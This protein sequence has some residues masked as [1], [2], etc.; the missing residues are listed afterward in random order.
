[1]PLT[2]GSRIVVRYATDQALWHERIALKQLQGSR[3]LLLTPDRDI[4][5]EDISIPGRGAVAAVRF[6]RDD[7]SFLGHGGLDCYRF[8]DST[9]GELPEE[10]LAEWIQECDALG[11]ETLPVQDNL[12]ATAIGGT[13]IGPAPR[14][15]NAGNLISDALAQSAPTPPA[16]KWLVLDGAKDCLAGSTVKDDWEIVRLGTKGV[17]RLGSGEV[18]FIHLVS[19]PSADAQSSGDVVID[20]K[21][22]ALERDRVDPR[23]LP[24]KHDPLGKR[25]IDFKDACDNSAPAK[26]ADFPIQGPLSCHWLMRHMLCNG[27]SPTNFH[28]RFMTDT[29]LDYSAGGMSEHM[30]LCKALELF[31]MY[32]QFDVTKSAGC[33]LIARKCQIIHER[34]KHKMPNLSP[35]NQAAGIEDDSYLLLGT[36]ETRGNLGVCPELA[37]WLGTELS[38]QALADK[39]RRKARE[40]RAL[41]VKQK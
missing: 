19:P 41:A 28:A 31:A 17:A 10:E 29:R 37:V 6:L 35:G 25:H 26:T 7:G 18:I 24:V 39:E 16:N 8:T 40:E 21:R 30:L 32:D 13:I 38:K 3:W 22:F 14:P 27:G 23:V 33:E 15:A 34:W 2:P 9:D 4:S 12:V 1:M 5:E 11:S 20:A 36:S